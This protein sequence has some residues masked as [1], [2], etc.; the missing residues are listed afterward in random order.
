MAEKNRI[1]YIDCTYTINS[2]E[3][4]GIQRVVLNI[5][6]RGNII[7]DVSGNDCIPVIF[8]KEVYI[9][10]IDY[11][12]INHM[13]INNFIYDFLHHD[14][15]NDIKKII[16]KN[17]FIIKI[18]EKL[19]SLIPGFFEKFFNIYSLIKKIF[20]FLTIRIIKI[21]FNKNDMLFMP[22]VFWDNDFKLS[23]VEK[24]SKNGVVII[25]LIYDIIPLLHPEI[26][27]DNIIEIF[28]QSFKKILTITN[29][30][31]T[32]SNSSKGAI[33]EY[34]NKNFFSKERYIDYFYLGSDFNI[35]QKSNLNI[36][37]VFLNLKSKKFFLTV[38]TIDLRKDQLTIVKSFQYLWSIGKTDDL[39]IIGRIGLKGDAV[40]EYIKKIRQFNKNLFVFNDINDLELE[41]LY[42][43][44]K[45]LIIASKAEGFGLPLIEAMQYG[46]KIVASDIDIF[47]EIAGNS[48]RYFKVGDFMSLSKELENLDCG[49]NKIYRSWI[50]WDESIRLL[51]NKLTLR[52]SFFEDAGKEP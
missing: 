47:H 20:M 2:G 18:R 44:S 33:E 52:N 26:C 25:N 8:Y 35:N 3:I 48:I 4:T 5:I 29:G 40:I 27:D 39:I 51:A 42:E 36:R 17:Y 50:S 34:I 7:S 22:D 32:I 45:A 15:E 6:K 24:L 9:K 12:L 1:I 16:K 21:K 38:G 31:I 30:I 10:L 19:F 43:N 46:L 23:F 11:A 14:N 41:F 13:E 37:P 49:N 28:E